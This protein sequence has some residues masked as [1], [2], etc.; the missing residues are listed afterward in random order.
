VELA[1]LLG[2][3]WGVVNNY[4]SLL[5]WGLYLIMYYLFLLVFGGGWG[6]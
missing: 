4:D 1:D 6:L 2:L 3:V 5:I